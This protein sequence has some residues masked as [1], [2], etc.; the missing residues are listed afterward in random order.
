[1]TELIV[2]MAIGM[3]LTCWILWF[4]IRRAM[5][6]A[7]QNLARINHVIDR[8]REGMILARVEEEAG[9]FYI[10]NTEDSSFMAQGT[11]VAEIKHKIEQRWQDVSVYVTEGDQD[12]IERLKS[13]T[14]QVETDRA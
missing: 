5:H 12:V 9:V 7:E 14:R 8:L 2:G 10:Y 1:M 4:M 13:T 11:T 6:R 3:A